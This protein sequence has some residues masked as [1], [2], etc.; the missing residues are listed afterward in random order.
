MNKWITTAAALGCA[1][2]CL[3]VSPAFAQL[4]YA[5]APLAHEPHATPAQKQTSDQAMQAGL[6]Q[7]QAA[8]AAIQQSTGGQVMQDLQ[9]AESAFSSA[10]PIYHGHREEAMHATVRAMDVVQ[11]NKKNA[12]ARAAA[13][14]AKAI[15]DA[16]TALQTN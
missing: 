10:M 12:R 6:S 9:A 4:P 5:P 14:V 16:Q 7:L 11:K 15:S 3:T 1:A 8:A 13:E 2:F